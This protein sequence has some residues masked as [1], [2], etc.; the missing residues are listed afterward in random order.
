MTTL[1]GAFRSLF[2][3]NMALQA[4]ERVLV[5]SDLIRPGETVSASDRDRR[6]RLN[7][8]ARGAADFAA[9][10]WG[11]ASFVEFPSTPASGA[12][13]PQELWLATFGE[14]T[15][16]ELDK[17]GLL[18]KLLA[19]SATPDEIAH[20]RQIVVAQRERVAD[21][22]IAMSNNSTSHT[23][24]RALANDAGARFASLPPFDPDMFHT[25]MTVDW[26]ALADRTA[27]LVAAVNRAEWVRVTTPNGTDMQICKQGRQAGGDDGLLTV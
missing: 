14:Q 6:T 5:F 16:A 8:T 11:S 18:G 27:R 13:P 15:T 24:Y 20:A 21:V 7:A 1:V 3:T 2:E 22:I 26:E 12:E 25:S 9:L 10:V 19:K 4:G 23:R 17:A